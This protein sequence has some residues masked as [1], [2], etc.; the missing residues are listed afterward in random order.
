MRA[1]AGPWNKR[2][3]YLVAAT[4]FLVVTS[5][6][7]FYKQPA[8]WNLGLW[9]LAVTVVV[10]LTH[11]EVLAHWPGRILA[12]AV[13]GLTAALMAQPGPLV[14]LVGAVAALSLAMIGRS[15]WQPRATQWVRR[16]LLFGL[17]GGFQILE[18]ALLYQRWRHKGHGS[19]LFAKVLLLMRRWLIPA[20]LTAGF[21]VL[22]AIANPVISRG[23]DDIDAFLQRIVEQLHID[24]VRVFFWLF[25][26]V[27]IWALL[28]KRI[29]KAKGA[30]RLGHWTEPQSMP[31]LVVR[32]LL[33]FN[34][35]FAI[36]NLLDLRY[37]YGGAA[38]PAAMTYAEYA[39]RGAYPLIA[40]A[41]LA[42]AFVLITFRPGGMT[43]QLQPARR[44]VIAW[45]AQ[46]V[47]L[48]LSA[49][50]RLHLYV[51]VY[52]LTRW[53]VA[54][55]VWMLLVAAGLAWTA[56]R[57]LSERPNEWLLNTNFATTLFVLYLCCFVNF[58]GMIA[59]YNVRHCREIA[60]EGVGIDV[61]YLRTLGPE[62]IPA[63]EWLSARTAGAPVGIAASGTAQALKNDLTRQMSNWR[64]WTLRNQ[65]LT[66]DQNNSQA[67]TRSFNL[68][69][70]QGV[71]LCLQVD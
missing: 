32:C 35:L 29:K 54:A 65:A 53:R 20:I 43:Q 30:V 24:V 47:F 68:I 48:T 3:S 13:L 57:I 55:T 26:G 51:Q 71:L 56:L 23:L 36:Q 12:L 11:R 5:D 17:T 61:G 63:L 4:V 37:L 15:G 6:W 16:W 69:G 34:A 28:R 19:P 42:G 18:D 33:L 44:L 31:A 50:W 64:G 67:E 41:L 27:G 52:S 9:E 62:A 60:G 22:F 40:T 38:L 59:W 25:V 66:T 21:L 58:N 7:L 1:A 2:A 45:L 49:L 14:V 39:H 8:G 10:I 46:N 70:S